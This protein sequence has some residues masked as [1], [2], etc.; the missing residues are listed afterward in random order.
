MKEKFSRFM[1]GRYGVDKLS[2]FISV[3]AIVIMFLSV[4]FRINILYYLSFG[5]LIYIYILEFFLEIFRRDTM[6]I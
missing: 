1:Y 5:L 3:L 4:I 6:K 2:R